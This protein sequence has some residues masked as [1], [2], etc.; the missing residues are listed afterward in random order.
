MRLT[1]KFQ[2]MIFVKKQENEKYG[3]V[4]NS[5]NMK[6]ARNHYRPKLKLTTKWTDALKITKT[7]TADR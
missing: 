7:K 5:N 4:G 1:G 2:Q 6:K 3:G